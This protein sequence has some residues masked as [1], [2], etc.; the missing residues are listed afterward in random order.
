[1]KIIEI[2]GFR[3]CSTENGI[4]EKFDN[5]IFVFTITN[6]YNIN[7]IYVFNN[8]NNDDISKLHN[9]LKINGSI[10]I[11]N[12]LYYSLIGKNF[13]SIKNDT[14][15][16]ILNNYKNNPYEINHNYD[17]NFNLTDSTLTEI[18]EEHIGCEL[19]DVL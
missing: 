16:Y 11:K 10:I 15:F 1:M 19:I 3:I 4:I 14:Q 12:K 8:S 17:F 7:D 2:T 18:F 6:E 5:G 13:M 9:I